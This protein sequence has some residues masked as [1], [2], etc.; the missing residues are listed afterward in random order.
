VRNVADFYRKLWSKGDAGVAIGLEVVA[1]TGTRQ[2]TVT[3]GDRR[4]YM[5]TGQSY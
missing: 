4:R 2:V 5:R 1:S 3:S